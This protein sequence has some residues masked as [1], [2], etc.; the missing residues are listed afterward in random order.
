[1]KKN[2]IPLVIT[3]CLFFVIELTVARQEFLI[4]LFYEKIQ[5]LICTS[6]SDSVDISTFEIEEKIDQSRKFSRNFDFDSAI[7][8]LEDTAVKDSLSITI[9]RELE[10]LYFKTSQNSKALNATNLILNSSDSSRYY[11]IHKG[12]LYKKIGEYGKALKLFNKAL[13]GDSSNVFLINHIGDLHQLQSESDSAL[14]FYERGCEIK[15]QTKSIIKSVNILLKED[16]K[17]LAL[18]FFSKY[19]SE[20][21]HANKILRR[22]YGKTMYLNDSVNASLSIFSELYEEGDSSKLTSK[23]LGMSHWKLKQYAEG[24]K[25]CEII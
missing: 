8:V 11:L 2:R 15:A 7:S 17:R 9:L 21:H 14:I 25:F 12:V 18:E 3:F 22:L 5:D 13:L 23:F 20:E 19:Y 16:M 6:S 4:P 24:K 10:N 1:M